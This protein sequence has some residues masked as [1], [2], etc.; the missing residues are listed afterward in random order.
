MA[1]K[2][3]FISLLIGLVIV[4]G[5]GSRVFHSGSPFL[6]KYLGDALYAVLFY[7]VLSLFWP[8]GKPLYKA[9]TVMAL[10]TA[11]EVFQLTQI[12]FRLS[13][14]PQIGLRILAILLGTEFHWGDLL[15]YLF[16]ITAILLVDQFTLGKS[17]GIKRAK[18]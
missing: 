6:D 16:G 5:I 3:R 12:P 15:A 18:T 7:L 14:N 13:Q 2:T 17:T 9:G 4:I 1:V 8:G 11:L 10:M